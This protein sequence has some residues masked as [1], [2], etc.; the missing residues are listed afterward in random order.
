MSFKDGVQYRGNK[1][2]TAQE[3]LQ[4]VKP[5]DIHN[6][7]CFKVFG[8]INPSRDDAPR[9]RANTVAHWKKSLS[10]FFAQA[11]MQKWNEEHQTGNPTQSVLINKLKKAVVKA[12]T[13]GN[14][15][16]SQ[17]NRPFTEGELHQILA[18][19][20]L[21][22]RHAAMVLFQ[23]HMI[24]RMDNV[25]HVKKSLLKV[26]CSHWSVVIFP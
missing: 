12:E 14:G 18:L 23:H 22:K 2:W 6:W 26:S 25:A 8:K 1:M 21:D 4:Q 9:N 5:I 19:L 16:A 15:A 20:R 13:R 7:M 3:L 10:H 24:G 17:A 11:T